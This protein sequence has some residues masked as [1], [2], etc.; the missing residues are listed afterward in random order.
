MTPIEQITAENGHDRATSAEQCSSEEISQPQHGHH[1]GHRWQYLRKWQVH[2]RNHLRG[3]LVERCVRA[4]QLHTQRRHQ[5]R[6]GHHQGRRAEDGG[7]EADRVLPSTLP[8]EVVFLLPMPL[9]LIH[10]H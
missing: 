2:H 9:T 1:P 7:L 3:G 10:S 4:H 8:N 6:T 5:G